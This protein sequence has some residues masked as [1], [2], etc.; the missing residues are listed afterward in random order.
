MA[1]S[2]ADLS[3]LMSIGRPFG[4][5]LP[6]IAGGGGGSGTGALDSGGGGGGDGTFDPG[7]NVSKLINSMVIIILIVLFMSIQ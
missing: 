5:E 4:T 3:L 2:N 1:P 6:F 7:K